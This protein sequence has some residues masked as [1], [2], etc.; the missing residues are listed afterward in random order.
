MRAE[1]FAVLRTPLLPFDELLRLSEVPADRAAVEAGIERLLARDD[2]RDAIALASPS[3]AQA[4]A[5]R[6]P[7]EPL[8]EKLARAAYRYLARMC[9]RPTPFGLF[10]GTSLCR[11]GPETTLALGPRERQRRS[12]T[13]DPQILTALAEHLAA[14]PEVRA[15]LAHRPNSSLYTLAGSARYARARTDG[16]RRSYELAVAE[17]TPALEALLER[18]AGGATPAELAAV[19]IEGGADPAAAAGFVDRVI[20]AQILAGDLVPPVT[21]PDPLSSLTGRLEALGV[22][23]AG[24]LATARERL[25]ELDAAGV[26]AAA[27]D[28]GP[29]IEV[30]RELPGDADP[31]RGL[32]A[33]LVRPVAGDEVGR[34]VI[35]EV[36]RALRLVARLT[37]A[38][39]G[40]SGPL[41]EWRRSFE[42]RY[43]T[44]EVPLMEA[45]DEELG[46]GFQPSTSPS[47]SGAPLL[48]GL[49]WGASM[50]ERPFD[51]RAGILLALIDRARAAGAI[52]V[53]L[54]P[55]DLDALEAPTPA[56][57]PDAL[58]ALVSVAA[59]G[60][61]L[62]HGASGPSGA[63][64]L[65]R[66]CHADPAVA[67][68]VREHLVREEALRPDA[69]FAELV[70]L[71]EGS[72]GKLIARPLLRGQEIEYL[73]RSGSDDPLPVDDLLVSV[74]GD[75]V[76]LRSRRLGKE[77]LPRLTSAH[78]HA[79][80]GSLGVYRFLGALQAQGRAGGLVWSWGA[81]DAAPFLPRV[82]SGRTVLSRAR[83]SLTAADLEALTA[84]GNDEARLAAAAALRDRHAL[85]RWVAVADADNE[86]VL[87]LENV[88]ALEAFARLAASRP[89]VGLVEVWPEPE[90][91]CVRGE[92]GRYMHELVV[93][94][95]A[96]QPTAPAPAAP[97]VAA[98]RRTFLPGSEWLY[99]KLYTGTA[100]A[101][102]L[103]RDL[104]APL[105][106]Q[107]DRWFFLRFGD[108]D[109]HLRLRL[110]GD[111][112]KLL[113]ALYAAAE[114]ERAAGRLW[115]LELGTYE[116]EIERYGGE[117]GLDACEAIFHADSQAVLAI[118]AAGAPPEARWRLAL[119]GVAMLLEDL[120]DDPQQRRAV[121]AAMRDG[122]AREHDAGRA[123]FRAIGE[124]WRAE[125]RDLRALLDGSAT[126]PG[127]EILRARSHVH[128][129]AVA[130]LRALAA[131]GALTLPLPEIAGSLVHMH[132][133]RL[134]RDA[135][136]AHELVLLDL[137]TRA[138]AAE[139]AR[140]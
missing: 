79:R 134:V 89:E 45:L 22:P 135:G 7:G 55:A 81:L 50:P 111:P 20:D 106:A 21:G 39:D 126:I 56:A 31:A 35:A 103:L 67:E 124:R 137:L 94:F 58:S 27:A 138:Y 87:D 46:I 118:V 34:D 119:A 29:V 129:P 99:A 116:R 59:D 98:A 122:Y 131:E 33:D 101:D 13:V 128:A 63:R 37:P 123:M 23:E 92:D 52:E 14:D 71:P 104:V 75:R 80:P 108:P 125:G 64:L 133:N 139:A 4:L 88:V 61:V 5:A 43:E 69:V 136:R 47:A 25:A 112:V 32:I 57:V 86:L 91:L 115:R 18:A 96:E 17:L 60:R 49:P 70:H 76:V 30:L 83:W 74:R 24:V 110:H 120:I 68:A 78:N 130:R 40:R 93:A 113:P 38:S 72:T 102:G 132:V 44:R 3:L 65:G 140:R 100:T 19:L 2:V 51:R 73:G 85:P 77:V 62:L 105:A 114:R 8:P 10:A 66:I 117:A 6:A 90:G 12:T 53:E 109:W 41:A 26:G 54:T 82:R 121:A 1:P 107:A 84:A 15:R 42:A 127:I 48:R 9:S 95:V 97:P 11:V 36:R 16:A 28:Y